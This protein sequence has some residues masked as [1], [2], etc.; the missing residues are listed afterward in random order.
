MEHLRQAE[1]A[2]AHA[3]VLVQEALADARGQPACMHARRLHAG[4][5]F[6]AVRFRDLCG[7]LP[8]LRMLHP[9]DRPVESAWTPAPWA[10][11]P[12]HV[13]TLSLAWG[14]LL[15]T[16]RAAASSRPQR[17]LRP[18]VSPASQSPRPRIISISRG[19]VR[20]AMLGK[21]AC[22]RCALTNLHRVPTARPCSAD[23][24]S[25]SNASRASAR[26][27]R[28]PNRARRRGSARAAGQGRSRTDS[29]LVPAARQ[30][31]GR[32]WN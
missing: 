28:R 3:H 15:G 13:G 22:F 30:R 21:R 2:L 10:C 24:S 16:R 32:C 31:R 23:Q 6:R 20:G 5:S 19:P 11:Q 17:M 7:N 1:T 26:A 27:T 12:P 8:M 25:S 29:G 14:E 18:L 9:A 4:R